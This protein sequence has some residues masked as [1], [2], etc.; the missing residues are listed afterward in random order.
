MGQYLFSIGSEIGLLLP[1]NPTSPAPLINPNFTAADMA[2]YT[3]CTHANT[4]A[5]VDLIPK[6][7]G[8]CI[9]GFCARTVI[10]SI[11][12]GGLLTDVL[13]WAYFN[14]AVNHL[15]IPVLEGSP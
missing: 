1:S 14:R 8:K 11:R 13:Q 5:N 15:R 3:Q 10:E 2:S 4:L 9:F 7:I 12:I 6:Y